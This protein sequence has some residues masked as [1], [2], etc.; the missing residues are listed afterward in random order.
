LLGVLS[1]APSS[2]SLA[3]KPPRPTTIAQLAAEAPRF[4]HEL[5]R[6]MSV[7]NTRE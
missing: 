7:R 2:A 1:C 3:L 5:T 6:P 4:A